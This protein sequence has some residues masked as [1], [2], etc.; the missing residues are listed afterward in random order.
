MKFKN[1]SLLIILSAGLVACQPKTSHVSNGGD[2]PFECIA[3]TITVAGKPMTTVIQWNAKTGMARLLDTMVVTSKATGA[4]NIA[5]GWM[6]LGD[7]QASIQEL[8]AH[9]QA[10]SQ[11]QQ[12]PQ[13]NVASPAPAQETVA[14]TSAKKKK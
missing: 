8:I 5:I 4:Q 11:A 13:S 14:A 12:A 2:G 10:A 6:P 7:L 9:N 1:L 3:A